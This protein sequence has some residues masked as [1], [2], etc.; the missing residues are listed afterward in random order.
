VSPN[1]ILNIA[2]SAGFDAQTMTFSGFPFPP[3]NPDTK[4]Y[5]AVL[6]VASAPA[7]LNLAGTLNAFS[8]LP[9]PVAAGEIVAL[10]V[11]DFKPA[12]DI[13]V[14]INLRLPL[15]TTLGGTQVLFDGKPAQVVSIA[16][17]K[18][19]AI[20]PQDF[21]NNQSTTIQVNANGTLSNPLQVAIASTALGL[22]SAD[23]SGT[24]LANARNED[25]T[26]NSAS[27]PAKRGTRMTIFFTGAGVPPAA[28]SLNFPDIVGIAPLQGFIP[29]IYSANFR[30]PTSLSYT[31]PLSVTLAAAGASEA[32]AGS[33]SQTL[34]IYMK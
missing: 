26:L 7:A 29:G 34:M 19:V 1:G 12:Q 33:I 2:G 23:G 9:G 13:N 21:A 27:N 4:A 17:G 25:G 14:G 10:S 18:I 5:L 30:V 24:G 8:L 3:P 6:N 31:S 16:A 11:P 28:I 22:L 20:A 32:I 15:G